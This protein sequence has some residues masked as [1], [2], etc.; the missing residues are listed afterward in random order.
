M[1]DN[2]KKIQNE[3]ITTVKL[4]LTRIHN[5]A[6]SKIKKMIN[7]ANMKNKKQRRNLLK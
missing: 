3:R 5:I 2:P 1:N 6:K 4:L 7:S